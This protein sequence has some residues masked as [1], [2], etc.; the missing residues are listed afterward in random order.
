MYCTY[1]IHVD[2]FINIFQPDV[3]NSSTAA[4]D[5]FRQDRE[6]AQRELLEREQRRKQLEQELMGGQGSAVGAPPPT[7]HGNGVVRTISPSQAGQTQRQVSRD[8]DVSIQ[9]LVYIFIASAPSPFLILY[10]SLPRPYMYM[11]NTNWIMSFKDILLHQIVLVCIKNYVLSYNRP[12]N[13]CMVVKT[14]TKIEK[15][16]KN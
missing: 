5:E 9:K 14:K 7:T 11:N 3:R 2:L 1:D 13:I 6:R 12:Y 15:E 16:K 10:I 4:Y 8:F